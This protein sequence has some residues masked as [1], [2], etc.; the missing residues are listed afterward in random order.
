MASLN[1]KIKKAKALGKDTKKAELAVPTGKAIY[2]NKNSKGYE[3]LDAAGKVKKTITGGNRA[4]STGTQKYSKSEL[5][6]AERL[7]AR[8]EK[9]TAKKIAVLGTSIKNDRS[10]TAMRAKIIEMNA[11]KKAAA[12]PV[13]KATKK[14]MTAS[15]KAFIK[16]QKEK[17][18][19]TKRTGV[20]PN[21][22]N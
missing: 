16:N 9:P 17:A 4:M 13:V 8:K 20:Y 12:K 15:E 14:P 5:A 22:A 19:A 2:I 7:V 3:A 18:K 21:T 6:A 10:K 1:D 11:K